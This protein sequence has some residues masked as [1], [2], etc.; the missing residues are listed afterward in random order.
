M[1][2]TK[3]NR[4]SLAT[5]TD[6]AAFTTNSYTP[7]ANMI[8]IA[9]VGNTKGTTPDAVNTFTDGLGLTWN[10]IHTV[11]D[12]GDL[13]RITQYWANSG[14][15][16]AATTATADFNGVNQ[17]ACYIHITEYDG[18]DLTDPIGDTDV[19]NPAATGL[20]LSIA[21]TMASTSNGCY[22]AI[23]STGTPTADATL[24]ATN[25]Q[26]IAVPTLSSPT[27]S[28]YLGWDSVNQTAPGFTW[29]TNSRTRWGA[30]FELVAAAGSVVG[31]STSNRTTRRRRR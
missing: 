31:Q 11:V 16:P 19:Q 3:T 14:A 28:L 30:G 22:V 15:S 7:S 10:L 26:Q 5:S 6:A 4:T 20:T 29:Q 17:T 18:L 27:Q 2:I 13:R 1:A 12:N 21:I 25:C 24:S 9:T 23:G 8:L